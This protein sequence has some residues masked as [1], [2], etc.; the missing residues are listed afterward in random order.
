MVY[1]GKMS[2][3]THA[4]QGSQTVP[5]PWNGKGGDG[6]SNACLCLYLLVECSVPC[7]FSPGFVSWFPS[8]FGVVDSGVSGSTSTRF[9][10]GFGEL[11]RDGG[12]G[13]GFPG[14]FDVPFLEAYMG[15]VG[16]VLEV[17]VWG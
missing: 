6:G 15:T 13:G 16:R 3:R 8:F 17:G 1:F 5:P 4:H 7:F 2:S 14:S 9:G 12:I 10:F 11:G